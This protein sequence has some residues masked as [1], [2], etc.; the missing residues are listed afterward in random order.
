VFAGVIGGLVLVIERPYRVGDTVEIG[1]DYGEVTGIGL[2]ST[3]LR[4]PDDTAVRVPNAA[5]FTSNVAN[6]NDGRP[7]MMVVVEIAVA[8][9]A[10]L[11]RA[12][13]IVGNALVT[14][15]Y[16]YVDEDHPVAVRVEDGTYYRTVRGKAYVADLR[17]EFAFAPDV[18]ERA[19]DAFEERGSRR[20]STWSLIRA[21]RTGETP[22]SRRAPPAGGRST[23]AGTNRSARPSARFRIGPPSYGL[24]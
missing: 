1:D 17:D 16:V 13:D 12:T 24:P 23:G 6:A 21:E 19:L 14:S 22:D 15:K 10:D 2:R 8:P 11:D 20:P 9:G 5:L 7:E 18:T 3:T 4:T